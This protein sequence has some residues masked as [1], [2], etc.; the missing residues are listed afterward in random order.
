VSDI[1]QARTDDEA[2]PLEYLSVVYSSIATV[3]FTE[4]DLAILLATSRMNNEP[5]DV[6][7]VLLHRAEHFMQALEGPVGAVR[8]LLRRIAADERHHDVRTLDEEYLTVRRF[9]SWSMGYRPLN[10]TDVAEAPAW[11]GSPE[12]LQRRDGFRAAELLAW[13]HSR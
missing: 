3:P 7:G 6:T 1:L 5:K 8:A 11:F 10:E 9:G 12:A 4:V 13:F 2:R